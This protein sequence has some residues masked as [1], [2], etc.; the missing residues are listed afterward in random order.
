MSEIETLEC[1]I[2]LTEDEMF[3]AAGQLQRELHALEEPI[4]ILS[5]DVHRLLC[6]SGRV[7]LEQKATEIVS[8]IRDTMAGLNLAPAQAQAER[9]AQLK[10]RIEWAQEQGRLAGAL[11]GGGTP[12]SAGRGLSARTVPI[13]P[14]PTA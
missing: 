4:R 9:L 8:R 10:D 11:A 12:A 5:Q 2:Y 13:D 6:E 7:P 1:R 14:G 3:L